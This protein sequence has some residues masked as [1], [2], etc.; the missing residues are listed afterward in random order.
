MLIIEKSVNLLA[1]WLNWMSGLAILAVM[2]ILCINVLSRDFFGMPLKGAVDL[3]SQMGVL[4]IAGAIAYTQ[5]LKSHIRISLLMDKLSK[6]VRTFLTALIDTIGAALFAVI[7]WQS[8]L[9]AKEAN[10]IGELS[11]VLKLPIAPFA[12][13]VSAG[14]IA[15][16]LVLLAD[17]IGAI[18]RRRDK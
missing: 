11:E 5:V 15:L 3:V 1:R 7:S 13:V 10:K 14:C 6:P 12:A 9:F 4:V 2:I 8:I 17:L 16:T 18:S